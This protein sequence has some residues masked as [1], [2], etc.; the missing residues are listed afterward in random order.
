MYE[1]K[2][3]KKNKKTKNNHKIN[4]AGIRRHPRSIGP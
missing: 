2:K 1:N 4:Y 3:T